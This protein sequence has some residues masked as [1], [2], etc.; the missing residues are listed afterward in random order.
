LGF[1]AAI[2]VG[3][4]ARIRFPCRRTRPGSFFRPGLWHPCRGV[5][6]AQAV[7]QVEQQLSSPLKRRVFEMS[8]QGHAVADIARALQYYER[9]VERARAEIR[10]LIEQLHDS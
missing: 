4:S 10:R 5:P 6:G 7:Q 9:G 3:V 2:V 1:P 8:L